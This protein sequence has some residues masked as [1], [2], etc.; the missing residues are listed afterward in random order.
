[1]SRLLYASAA[2]GRLPG[3]FARLDRRAVPRRDVLALTAAFAAV[4]CVTV[5]APR[6]LV[7]LVLAASTVFML[8]YVLALL[9]YLRAERRPGRRA[10]A[11]ALLAFML[12]VAAGAGWKVLYPLAVFAAALA[13]SLARSRGQASLARGRR[14]VT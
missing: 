9:S 5:A 1:M 2:A 14:R 12:V 11:A 10:L 7:E 8:L 13:T 6:L 3:W 4:T